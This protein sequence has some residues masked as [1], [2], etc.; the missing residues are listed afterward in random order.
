[1][2][3]C[4]DS[5]IESE[6]EEENEH[7]AVTDEEE[8]LK[9]A[10]DG[11]L[12]IIKK[13]LSLQGLENEQQRENIFHTRCQVQGKVC[14]VIINGGRCTNMVSTLMVEKLGLPTTKHPD[15]YKFQW[16][17][18]GG[19]LKVTKQVLVTF[20]IGKYSDEVLC[21]T[22]P[23]HVGHLLLRR[24]W[25]F[26]RR[27][28]HDGYTNRYTF[29]HLGKTVTLALLTSKQVYEDQVRLKNSIEQMKE[30]EKSESSKGKKIEKKKGKVK[31][32]SEKNERKETVE[33]ET[34][35]EKMNVFAKSS[36]VRKAFLMRQLILVLMYKENLLNTNDFSENLPSSM[37]SLLQDFKDVFSD[38]VPRGLAHLCGIEHQIDFVPG[39]SLSPCAVPVLLVP[40]KD[41]T[42][43]MCVDCHAVN[44]ITVKYRHPILRLDDMLDELIGAK[45]FSKID[46]KSRYHQIR[47]RE[48]DEWKTT[49]KAKHGLYEWSILEVLRKE[50]LYANLKNCT[51][52]SDKVVFLG[53]VRFVPNFS[54]LA[55]PLTSVIKKNSAFHWG[56][57]QEK[58]FTIIKDRITKAP[59]LALPD[60]T[61]TFEIGC[62]ASGVGIGVVLTEGGRPITYFSEKLNEATLNYP[63]YDKEMYSLIRALETWQ[64]YLWLKEFMIHSDHEALKHIKG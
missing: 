54:T 39:A 52:C 26:D 34:D 38:D 41:R 55:A 21:N 15:P 14:C 27:V 36:D 6:E 33:K 57:E 51:F 22:V 29:K 1:M 64:H 12:L 19:E 56:K 4:A 5:K 61:K 13:S 45:L 47:M 8:K 59:L 11:E 32:E 3:V 10:V 25:Q 50:T 37:M 40:K 9:H 60:F 17:N 28:T 43:H 31:K 63:V 48:G 7:D 46:L 16:L 23:M 2:V 42:W 58:A 35:Y 24:P 44:K 53:F 49:F 18:D 30:K 20:S 62:D